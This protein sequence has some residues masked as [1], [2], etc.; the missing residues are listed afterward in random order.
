MH[1]LSIGETIT[2]R[3]RVGDITAVTDTEALLQWRYPDFG[4][5]LVPISGDYPQLAER[6]PHFGDWA[7][8]NKDSRVVLRTAR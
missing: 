3:G 7:Q 5:L 2:I 6:H 1:K 4:A 8:R